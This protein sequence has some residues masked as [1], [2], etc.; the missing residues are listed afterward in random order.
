MT[1][2][3]TTNP[4]PVQD[5]PAE[6]VPRKRP[7]RKPLPPDQRLQTISVGIRPAVVAWLKDQGAVP[8]VVR[9]IVEQ[10]YA[11]EPPEPAPAE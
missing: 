4:E 5:Q 11:K 1:E 3:P 9:V 7:G 6:W 2:E 8:S 10:A